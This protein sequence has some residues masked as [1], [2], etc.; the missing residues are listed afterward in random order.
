M[1][2][3]LPRRWRSYLFGL[4]LD[5][6]HK[7]E[8][9]VKHEPEMNHEPKLIKLTPGLPLKIQKVQKSYEPFYQKMTF[10]FDNYFW[11]TKFFLTWW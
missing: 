6:V 1:L 11:K 10:N 8:P 2:Y 3:I 5:K 9:E 7:H 4:F